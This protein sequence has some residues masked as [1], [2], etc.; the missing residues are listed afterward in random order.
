MFRISFLVNLFVLG[1]VYNKDKIIC[2]NVT[3]FIDVRCCY[4]MKWLWMIIGVYDT[5]VKCEDNIKCWISRWRYVMQSSQVTI[6]MTRPMIRHCIF[7]PG[8]R[9]FYIIIHGNVTS[10]SSHNKMVTTLIS[11]DIFIP[12]SKQLWHRYILWYIIE[13][14]ILSSIPK[15]W[16]SFRRMYLYLH[17]PPIILYFA[18]R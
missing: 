8:R 5:V 6:F 1:F 2:T 15:Y 11:N 17:G 16:P 7:T 4:Y 18:F 3:F 9:C 13:R 14:F 12:K 10:F